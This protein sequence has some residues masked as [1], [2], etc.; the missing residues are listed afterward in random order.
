MSLPGDSASGQVPVFV[1]FCS[2]ITCTWIMACGGM[3]TRSAA[4]APSRRAGDG[5]SPY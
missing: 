5:P 2:N 3:T 1:D 4:H